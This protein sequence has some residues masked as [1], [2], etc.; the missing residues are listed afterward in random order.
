MHV[1]IIIFDKLNAFLINIYEK[2]IT[3]PKIC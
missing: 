2:S 3:D 1:F